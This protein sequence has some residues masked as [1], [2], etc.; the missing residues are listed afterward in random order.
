MVRIIIQIQA[1][2]CFI[3]SEFW[4][5]MVLFIAGYGRFCFRFDPMR[6]RE[7]SRERKPGKR[8]EERWMDGG[9]VGPGVKR[10]RNST[11]PNHVCPSTRF[12]KWKLSL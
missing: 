5:R 10:W 11:P 6:E 12:L 2:N 8:S 7:R 3:H 9:G 1:K 4:P